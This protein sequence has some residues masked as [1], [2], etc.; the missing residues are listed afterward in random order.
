[1][2]PINALAARFAGRPLLLARDRLQGLLALPSDDQ[3]D[4]PQPTRPAPITTINGI[5]MVTIVGPMVARSDWLSDLFDAPSYAEIGDTIEAA[6]TAEATRAVI[7]EIDTP[8]G[9]VGGLF[10]L[11]DRIAALRQETGKPL[12]AVASEA[13]LSGGYA[14]ACLADHLYVTQAGEVGSVGVIALHLDQSGAD[15]EAGLRWNFITAGERKADGNAHEPLS[16]RA[17]A[18]IQA[19]VD[20]IHDRFVALVARQR[21]MTEDA[22]RATEA[23]I[24]RGQRGIEIGL[25]DQ[26]GTIDRA[27]ADLASSL[28]TV[29]AAGPAMPTRAAKERSRSMTTQSPEPVPAEPQPEPT[30]PVLPP[31]PDPPP[32]P[33]TPDPAHSLRAEYSEIAAIAAQAGRLGIAVDAADALRRGLK[34]DA[35]RRSVLDALAARA[36]AQT[37]IAASPSPPVAGDSPIVRRARERAAAKG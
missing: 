23:A 30:P 5:A 18:D 22:V 14:I 8:G 26:V 36:E 11:T 34:P 1:M 10:D 4:W 16:D 33:T 20:A 28:E 24:Y 19:D 21:G 27:L 32:A 15:A 3:G 25:A 6:F 35:L 31:T 17:R 29:R 13:A 12:W 2:Y 9:E 37:V 7:L